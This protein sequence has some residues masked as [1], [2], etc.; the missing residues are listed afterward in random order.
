MASL[1]ARHSRSCSLG[2]PWTTFAEAT[3]QKGCTCTP[4]YHVVLRHDSELVREPVGHNRREAERALDARRGD[5]ARR[6][7]KVIDDI[8][9]DAWADRWLAGFTGE[10]NSATTSFMSRW[11]RFS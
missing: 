5:V 1:Q 9:F 2:R 8:R 11:F 10:E 7:Y 3:K 4:L 6:T